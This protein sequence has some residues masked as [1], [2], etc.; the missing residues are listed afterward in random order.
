M[1]MM[2]APM[3]SAS[4]PAAATTAS[5]WGLPRTSARVRMDNGA[6]GA[7]PNR[8]SFS[9]TEVGGSSVSTTTGVGDVGLPQKSRPLSRAAMSAHVSELFPAFSR[10][11]RTVRA[12]RAR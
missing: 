2:P 1:T 9:A 5:H 3:R 8:S 7:T 11:P 12:P 4:A 10:A 6:S